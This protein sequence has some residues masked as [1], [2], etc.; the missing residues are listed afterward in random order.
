MKILKKFGKLLGSKKKIEKAQSISS[1]AVFG[2]ADA[3]PQDKEFK[4]CFEVC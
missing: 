4:D 2:Y 1:I 3:K